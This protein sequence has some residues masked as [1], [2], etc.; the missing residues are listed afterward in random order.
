M[1]DGQAQFIDRCPRRRAQ[2][3]VR[4]DEHA[5]AALGVVDR[6]FLDAVAVLF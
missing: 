4:R 3:L 6:A 5:L 2:R 1:R